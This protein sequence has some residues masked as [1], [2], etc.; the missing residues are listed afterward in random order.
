MCCGQ[1]EYFVSVFISEKMKPYSSLSYQT[2][3]E[4]ATT[5]VEN[6]IL[7]PAPV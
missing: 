1:G 4:S 2:P 6:S 3:A 5:Q 7:T